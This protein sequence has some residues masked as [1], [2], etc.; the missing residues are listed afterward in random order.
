[1]LKNR[2]IAV[3][4]GFA[5]CATLGVAGAGSASATSGSLSSCEYNSSVTVE[6]CVTMNY[7][8]RVG[9][10]STGRFYFYEVTSLSYKVRR[11]DSQIA[12][13]SMSVHEGAYAKTWDFS[14]N[15][16]GTIVQ[17]SD[18]IQGTRS[19][20][21]SGTT[22]S[23]AGHWPTT[24]TLPWSPASSSHAAWVSVVTKRGTASPVTFTAGRLYLPDSPA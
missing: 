12:L 16:Y 10:L 17:C 23:A 1:M 8:K 14:R 6:V 9:G 20:P 24:Y 4:T 18:C 5:L 15:A 11:I 21:T 13:V 3:L 2:F 22:Y 19:Y 7:D